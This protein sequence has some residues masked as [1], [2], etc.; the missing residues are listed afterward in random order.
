MADLSLTAAQ[1]SPVFPDKAEIYTF[2]AVEAIT[3]GQAVYLVAASGK[4]GVADAN[5]SGKQQLRGIALNAAAAGEPV[6]VMK[7]GHIYGFTLTSQDYDDAVYLS[8]TAGALGDAAGTMTVNAGR[9]VSL[10][11]HSLTKV[12]YLDVNWA[13]VWS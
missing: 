7:T 8:D 3:K 2:I 11:D 13:T 12:V 6:A 10:S 4:V 5:A 1:I 9:V